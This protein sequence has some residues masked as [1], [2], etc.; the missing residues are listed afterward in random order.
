MLPVIVRN[1]FNLHLAG[2]ARPVSDSVCYFI[3]KIVLCHHFPPDNKGAEIGFYP[4]PR[5][6]FTCKHQVSCFFNPLLAGT[7]LFPSWAL[8]KRGRNLPGQSSLYPDKSS[9]SYP[10]H[11]IPPHLTAPSCA[12]GILPVILHC[13]G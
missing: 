2:T 9:F 13:N 3:N 10:A 5:L 6:C 8:Q 1:F 7:L 12:H 11:A 4:V